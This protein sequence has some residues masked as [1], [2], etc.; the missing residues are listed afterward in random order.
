M[1]GLLTASSI[2]GV[3]R[4]VSPS[5]PPGFFTPWGAAFVWYHTHLAGTLPDRE[6]TE[7][8]KLT[9]RYPYERT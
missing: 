7:P 3:S 8:T 1:S 5:V 4:W 2:M 6:D 9:H